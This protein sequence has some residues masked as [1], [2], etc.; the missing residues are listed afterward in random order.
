MTARQPFTKLCQ[1]LARSWRAA[2][3]DLHIH[4]TCSDGAYTPVEVVDLAR[5]SGLPALAITDHDTIDA[6]APA[7][8]AA[9]T[10]LEV[11]PG[12]EITSQFQDRSLH[13]LG[14]FFRTEDPGLTGLLSRLREHRRHR[15][16]EMLVRLARQGVVLT[17]PNEGTFG[18]LGRR[19]VA[20]LLVR[21]GYAATVRQAFVRYLG[22]DGRVHVPHFELPVEEA[23]GVVRGAGGVAAWAHPSYDC[24]RETLTGLRAKG[25]Q[26]LEVEWPSC[27]RS[28]SRELRA[29]A[30]ELDLAVAGGSDCHGPGNHLRAVGAHGITVDELER[31]RSL[32]EA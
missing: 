12:I 11:V 8:L 13:L 9:G 24:T 25:L 14:F 3:V 17:V 31:L 27:R 23:I 29:W 26:A 1:Q 16:R 19:H 18:S 4:T 10:A 5:R 32:A 21:A 20:E 28:R 2:R 30:A 7:C 6:L 15:F 22:D